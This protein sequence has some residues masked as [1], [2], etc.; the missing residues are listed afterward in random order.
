MKKRSTGA[1]VNQQK[2]AFSKS[3]LFCLISAL[4][5]FLNTKQKIKVTGLMLPIQEE[6]LKLQTNVKCSRGEEKVEIEEERERQKEEEDIE[7]QKEVE[8]EKIF[9][10][11]FAHEK[12]PS[13]STL[14]IDF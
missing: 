3:T 14:S 8:N 5:S 11:H 10:N 9:C 13:D 2:S 12:T 1:P 4:K 7:K 6:Q